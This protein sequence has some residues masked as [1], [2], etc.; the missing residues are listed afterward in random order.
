MKATLFVNYTLPIYD[1]QLKV[2]RNKLITILQHLPVQINITDLH[3]DTRDVAI[4]WIQLDRL[5]KAF[6]NME[7]KIK[8]R[9]LA[10]IM[11]IA[12]NGFDL[13][14]NTAMH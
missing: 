3:Q 12:Q 2:K 8:V 5:Q 9:I 13:I 6:H 7:T 14:R 4:A 10:F 1:S 11:N